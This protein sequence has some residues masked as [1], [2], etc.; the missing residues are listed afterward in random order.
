MQR[1]LIGGGRLPG[2]P[3]EAARYG[4]FLHISGQIAV[5]PSTGRIAT[6]AED[7]SPE[8]R[9]RLAEHHFVDEREWTITVQTWQ[10]YENMRH[11]LE[12]HGAT[13]DHLV[14]TNTFFRDLDDFPGMER[15]RAS[16]LVRNPP[17]STVLEMSD[18]GLHPDIHL[19]IDGLAILPSDGMAEVAKT[20]VGTSIAAPAHYS[21]ALRAGQLVWPAGQT[22]Y[23]PKT[24]ET[25]YQVENLP[26][27][28]RFLA[29]GN[30][31][32]DR[33]EGPALAQTWS[34]YDNLRTILTEAG[35][36]LNDILKETIW[37][38]H[39]YHFPNVERVRRH[40]FPDPDRA[41]AVTMLQTADL[42]RTKDTLLEIDVVA[43][44]PGAGPWR[45]D[46]I[47][48]AGGLSSGLHAPIAVKAGPLLFVSGQTGLH[49]AAGA[50]LLAGR[51]YLPNEAGEQAW[52]T[53][54]RLLAILEAQGAGPD[55]LLKL[56]VYT[57]RHD[58]LPH[59]ERALE[60]RLGRLP[61]MLALAKPSVDR[62]PRV[63]VKLDAI[64]ALPSRG[65]EDEDV[66]V[67]P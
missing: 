24:R 27:E 59:V 32:L 58:D 9:A 55:D 65:D 6:R 35:S 66:Q 28:G 19:L 22:A 31:H 7:I 50:G 57:T 63:A 4:P 48:E 23:D 8:A 64:A 56:N 25:I 46:V 60:A 20:A 41:P 21:M 10:I 53:A 5:D 43:L 3:A 67:G 36:S 62:D 29:T 40:F 45:K 12:P 38:R 16:F 51:P 15:A 34:V 1:E 42:G 14:R 18:R 61:A 47:V 33:R 11:L 30:K 26:E 49:E 17:A 39:P 54:G 44:A 13:L 52:S 2:I 37:V